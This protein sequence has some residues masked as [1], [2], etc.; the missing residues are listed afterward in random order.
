MLRISIEDEDAIAF[1]SFMRA[2]N[3]ENNKNVSY[4]F[5][6]IF[7]DVYEFLLILYV[8]RSIQVE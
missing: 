4:N 6:N 1:N 8:S 2:H 7:R 5:P 3:T